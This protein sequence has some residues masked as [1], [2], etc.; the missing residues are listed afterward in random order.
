MDLNDKE[1]ESIFEPAG[2]IPKCPRDP[3]FDQAEAKSQNP[4]TV[5]HVGGRNISKSYAASQGTLAGDWIR[6]ME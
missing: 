5:T 4:I 1:R 2:S 6:S 3:E